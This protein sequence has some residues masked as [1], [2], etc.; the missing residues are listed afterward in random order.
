MRSRGCLPS[1]PATPACSTPPNWI[2]VFSLPPNVVLPCLSSGF[3]GT[4]S[5]VHAHICRRPT[6]RLKRSV[7]DAPSLTA[8]GAGPI[9]VFVPPN[10]PAVWTAPLLPVFRSLRCPPHG[11]L[12]MSPGGSLKEAS[13][14]LLTSRESQL[15][16]GS[17]VLGRPR[18]NRYRCRPGRSPGVR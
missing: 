7:T 17:S 2:L 15:I 16:L 13:R 6:P 11:F 8:P 5:L 3:R 14:I 10:A 9:L 4:V 1:G 12:K 18:G